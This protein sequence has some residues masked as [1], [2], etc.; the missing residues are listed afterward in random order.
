MATLSAKE[1]DVLDLVLAGLANKNIAKRLGYSLKTIEV[2]RQAVMHKLQA[3][4]VAQLV[5]TA[6]VAEPNW[7]LPARLATP[8][9]RTGQRVDAPAAAPLPVVWPS[10]VSTPSAIG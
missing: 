6:L 8:L 7:Q 5:R 2:R 9:P 1:R 3:D 10:S 4:S